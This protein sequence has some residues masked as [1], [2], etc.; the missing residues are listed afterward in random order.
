MDKVEIVVIGAGAA[1]LAAARRLRAAGGEVLVLEARDRIGGRAH[2]AA[3]EGWPMD[4]GCGW[5]HSGDRNPWTELADRLEFTIDQTEPPWR[6]PPVGDVLSRTDHEAFQAAMGAFDGRLAAAAGAG[7]EGPASALLEPEGRW[8]PLIDAVSSW[9]NG[10]ELDRI[11]VLDYAAFDD[12]EVNWRAPEG[13]GALIEAYGTGVPVRLESAVRSID[14]SG[15]LLRIVTIEG[16][17]VAEQAVVAVPTAILA[18]GR[19]RITPDLPEVLEACAGLPLGLADKVVLALDE[20][21]AFSPDAGLFGRTD[22]R[23]T[24]SYHLRPFGRP[25]VEV[26]LGGRWA[27]ELEAEGP[28]APTAFALEELTAVFGSGL[29]RKLR[30]LAET[31]WAADPFAR[32]SYSHALP[33]HAGARADP[34]KRARA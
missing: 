26:F 6:R 11:S 4:L 17:L 32:G 15:P 28:G 23:E 34:A 7:E 22:T 8:N 31:A 27:A 16:E 1:G 13:Y 3:L 20:P 10:A 29:R 12:D 33:G 21:G 25:L 18:E 14:R 2:T 5:L 9:Y 19:L 30:P 24:G